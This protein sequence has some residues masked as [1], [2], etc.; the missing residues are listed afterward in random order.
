M[1]F[2]L[3][4][5]LLFSSCQLHPW[6]SISFWFLYRCLSLSVLLTLH[7]P[8]LCVL[9]CVCSCVRDAVRICHSNQSVRVIW[10]ILAGCQT[11]SPPSRGRA[12][13]PFIY[14]TT[15]TPWRGTRT[16]PSPWTAPLPV[17][18]VVAG[19]YHWGCCCG[20]VGYCC[21]NAVWWIFG[22]I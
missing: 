14:F 15:P 20:G 16:P 11:D 18:S 21:S 7:S 17:V 9:M 4:L 19:L 6:S 2:G 10:S 3:F 13:I 1:S 12:L 22:W 5:G 8:L